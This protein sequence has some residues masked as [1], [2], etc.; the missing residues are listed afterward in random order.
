MQELGVRKQDSRSAQVVPLA[1]LQHNVLPA[2]V[3]TLQN[4]PRV[5]PAGKLGCSVLVQYRQLLVQ[6]VYLTLHML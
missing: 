6:T 1:H 2:H 5:K 4:T 3:R